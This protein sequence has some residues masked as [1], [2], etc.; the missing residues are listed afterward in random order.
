[1]NIEE[2]LGKKEIADKLRQYA[3]LLSR[4]NERARLTGPSDP[5]VLY[6]DFILDALYGLAFLGDGEIF[7]DVGTG[8]GLPGIAWGICRP[9]A[10]GFLLDSIGK[11]IALVS[12]M[13]DELDCGNLTAVNARS[14][15]FTAEHREAFDVATARA[16]AAAPLLAEYLTPLVRIGGK[17]VA[18]KGEN[19]RDELNLPEKAWQKLGLSP[20]RL[21]AY[22]ISG[23]QRY[24]VLWEKIKTCGK[25]YPRRPGMADKIPWYV[26]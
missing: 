22:E 3:E 18:F 8:G 1:M 13:I 9:D 6:E 4:A 2:Y 26:N 19:V 25:K 16:V 10:K 24:L 15:D 23:K 21:E 5:G 11:K 12:E 7:V 14:E 17:I 20:P